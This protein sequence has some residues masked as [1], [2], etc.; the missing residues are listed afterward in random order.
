MC[1]HF[2]EPMAEVYIANRNDYP[3]PDSHIYCLCSRV[4]IR[5]PE[6]YTVLTQE[7]ASEPENGETDYLGEML[8]DLKQIPLEPPQYT[9]KHDEEPVSCYCSA[10]HTDNNYSTDEHDSVRDSVQRSTTYALGQKLSLHQSDSGADLSEYHEH[11][12]KPPT[13]SLL[14]SDHLLK[15]PEVKL[16]N[17]R[18]FTTLDSFNKY[19]ENPSES[20]NSNFQEEAKRKDEVLN[21]SDTPEH[22]SFTLGTHEQSESPTEA[23]DF[24]IIEMYDSYLNVH[25][26]YGSDKKSMIDIAWEKFWADH[27]ERLI[28]SS[29]I[30]KYADYINPSYIPPEETVEIEKPTKIR[31]V[32]KFPEQNTCFPTCA[33]KNCDIGRSNFEGLFSRSD[34]PKD[35]LNFT[36]DDSTKQVNE[37]D[38]EDNRK[39]M[40][41]FELSPEIDGWN[42]LSP[43]SAEESYNQHSHEDER[44]ITISRCDSITGS[45]AKTNAT[46][47]SMTNVTKL[48]LTNSSFDS[49]SQQSL[50][51]FSSV[52]SS[53]ESNVTSSSSDQDNDMTSDNDRYWQLLWKENFQIQYQYHYSCFVNRYMMVQTESSTSNSSRIPFAN[54]SFE[55]APTESV[56]DGKNGTKKSASKR[57]LNSK[58]KVVDSVGY[59]MQNLT[60]KSEDNEP[61]HKDTS[62]REGG[63]QGNAG[64]VHHS[65]TP[66]ANHNSSFN[67]KRSSNGASSDGEKPH[68]DKPVTLKRSHEAD[69]D[70]AQEGMETVKKAFSLMG[71]TFR[72][73]QKEVK[74]QGEVVYRKRHIR[75]PNRQL[76]MK[77]NRNKTNKHIYFDENGVEITSTIDKVK[78]YLSDCPIKLSNEA[79][80]QAND[81]GS[82]TKAHFT[83]SSDEECDE[84]VSTKLHAKRLVFSKPST[85][86]L[87][88]PP[89]FNASYRTCDDDVFEDDNKLEIGAQM[90][91]DHHD[92]GDVITIKVSD[93]DGGKKAIKKRRRKQNKRNVSLPVEVDNDRT[94]MKYWV[95]RYR[96][97]SKFD[98]GVK[99]DRESWFSVTPEK[100]AAHIADRCQ[101]DTIVDAFCGAG[102]NTIQF[103]FKCERV[104]AIDIDPNKIELARNNARVYG[105]EDRIDFI[106][107]DFFQIADKL[108]ADVVFLSPPW[109]GPDYL[110]DETY[111]L[112]SILK[113]LGGMTLFNTARMISEHV[114]YFLPRNIDTIQLAML[115]GPGQ[116]VEIEQNFLD[117][118]LVALTAYYG[119]LPKDC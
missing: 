24:A 76:K 17:S 115:A 77:L 72:E 26:V 8:D 69:F 3:D 52:T 6:I 41:N 44:L 86:S 97:F 39:K 108:I 84:P 18:S 65:T 110:H 14:L 74:L 46:S 73:N 31:V 95:K 27:G 23:E 87:E 67:C 35:Q 113:P 49:S 116:G 21:F 7:D 89:D 16:K 105:V 43:F 12:A 2:W 45:L 70:E 28:W 9:E 60:M 107:G 51:L 80:L 34:K 62:Q 92:M 55:E 82:Y 100:I 10:S 114:A 47:D 66:S 53:I 118:K 93:E 11:D 57:R 94:L 71:Y 22:A 88:T 64:Q 40:G 90:E 61:E 101:C 68:E 59:L 119:E 56:L 5:N 96:L 109:G 99:L 1:D 48:T 79:E 117:R 36:F 58:R 33:H 19:R 106:V 42:P 38:A 13:N 29:W 37:R 30:T 85:S 112:N 15:T 104:I 102:G 54:E 32:E 91:M 83:S 111:D 50:S 20:D 103:A 78:Q 63:S 25:V 81:K 4:F 75:L 98:Q